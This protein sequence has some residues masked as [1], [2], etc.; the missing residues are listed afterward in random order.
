MGISDFWISLLN[1]TQIIITNHVK[2]FYEILSLVIVKNFQ[3][4]MFSKFQIVT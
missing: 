1:L 3:E 4:Y 2:I